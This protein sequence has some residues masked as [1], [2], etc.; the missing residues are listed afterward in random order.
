MPK[1]PVRH[2]ESSL[3]GWSRVPWAAVV[4]VV[5][6]AALLPLVIDSSYL[7]SVLV[8][9]LIYAVLTQSWNLT[10]GMLGM[11]NFGQLA[12]YAAG[13]Y[14]A[15][16]AVV[17][18]GLSTWV[19]LPIG[20]ATAVV[21]NLVIA[22]PSM[23][24]RGIYVGMLTFAFSE[25]LRLV[26]LADTTGLTGGV[27][28]MS[29]VGGLFDFLSPAMSQRAMYWFCLLVC[30]A[31][32]FLVRRLMQSPSGGAF[33]ALK[34]STRYAVSLGVNRRTYFMF[35][36]TIAAALAG[37]AG[38]LYIFQFSTMGPT[39]MGLG[40]LSLFLFMI[41]VGGMGTYSGPIV[42]TFAVVLLNE[43]LKNFGDWRVLVLG[44]LLL[45]I[46]IA[47]PT[48]LVPLGAQLVSRLS[49]WMNADKS[50][51]TQN[52]SPVDSGEPSAPEGS[53]DAASV[54]GIDA[55]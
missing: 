38:A 19:A 5:V 51:E 25:V 26:I 31:T 47:R 36:T 37:A 27:F 43:Y 17:H 30:L 7:M 33:H 50:H 39:V 18:L 9:G 45:G 11:W 16:I 40:N 22:I 23:R 49:V 53:A 35:C 55:D 15:G 41:M 10:I 8:L 48:G 14:G 4:P 6:V 13:G 2:F 28:G 42:G 20:A 46:L 21:M 54:S 3:L 34:D 12:L 44:C 32:A 52:D 29:G 24:L 1:S